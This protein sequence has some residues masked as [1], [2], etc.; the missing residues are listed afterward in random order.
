MLPLAFS[1]IKNEGFF[2]SPIKS[3]GIERED[4]SVQAVFQEDV[5]ENCPESTREQTRCWF[6]LRV[7][8]NRAKKTWRLVRSPLLSWSRYLPNLS[9]LFLCLPWRMSSLYGWYEAEPY[10]SVPAHM[11]GGLN[12]LTCALDCNSSSRLTGE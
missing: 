7:R 5:W 9:Q 8:G 10:N 12:A 3:M 6:V 11:P 1:S 2:W 4:S